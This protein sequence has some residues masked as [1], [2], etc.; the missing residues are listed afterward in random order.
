MCKPQ[1]AKPLAV[2][3]ALP[4]DYP[5]WKQVYNTFARWRLRSVWDA[6]LRQQARA[7]AGGLSFS[8]VII[9]SQSIQTVWESA[10]M[11]QAKE[12]KDAS[13]I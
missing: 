13:A 7:K 3:S 5:P 4:R 2:S 12:S 11:T 1:A 6:L 9:D 8:V 10:D